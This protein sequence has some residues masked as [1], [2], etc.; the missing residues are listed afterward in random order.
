MS[1][2]GEVSVGLGRWRDIFISGTGRE[3]LLL[4]LPKIKMKKNTHKQK[5]SALTK[6]IVSGRQDTVQPC[7]R[8][9]VNHYYTGKG[10]DKAWS[11]REKQAKW[12]N[13]ESPQINPQVARA[14][15]KFWLRGFYF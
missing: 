4:F 11:P 3:L 5:V 1:D 8:W 13:T 9:S 15:E 7:S 2:Y 12:R 14:S 6:H 10:A